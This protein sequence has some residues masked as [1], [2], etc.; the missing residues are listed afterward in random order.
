MVQLELEDD[1]IQVDFAHILRLNTQHPADAVGR[2]DNI[3]T[4]TV[5][6]LCHARLSL[7]SALDSAEKPLRSW[8]RPKVLQ[9]PDRRTRSLVATRHRGRRFIAARS[10]AYLWPSSPLCVR[11]DRKSKRMNSSH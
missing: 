3:I 5:F 11:R 4:F 9:R 10:L 7:Q 2:I 1:Q 8:F 6:A